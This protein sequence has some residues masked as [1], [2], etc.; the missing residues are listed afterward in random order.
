MHASYIFIFL[1]SFSTS[2]WL[3]LLYH[4]LLYQDVT[5]GMTFLWQKVTIQRIT[6]E[7]FFSFEL[8]A[9]LACMPSP[10]LLLL[11]NKINGFGRSF[12]PSGRSS[13]N[14]IGPLLS[15]EGIDFTVPSPFVYSFGKSSS[16]SR[17]LRFERCGEYQS[18]AEY[19]FYAVTLCVIRWLGDC[20]WQG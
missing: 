20:L 9:I 19:D 14:R 2:V 18:E 15:T 7:R 6:T 17:G 3:N 16:Q 10:R 1:W 4:L 11:K 13:W 8:L 12:L 5:C